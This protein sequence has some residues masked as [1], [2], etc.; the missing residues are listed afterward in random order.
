MMRKDRKLNVKALILFGAC[1]SSVIFSF[2]FVIPPKVSAASAGTTAAQFLKIALN[3]K[4]EG[5]GGAGAA[6]Y[7]D[8]IFYNPASVSKM[9]EIS[10]RAGY[11]SWFENISKSNAFCVVPLGAN[12]WK[13]AGNISYFTVGGLKEYSAEAASPSDSSVSFDRNSYSVSAALAK[14]FGKLSLGA[15]LKGV[16]EIY[17]SENGNAVAADAGF[18]FDISR[19]LSVA[20]VFQ[21]FGTKLGIAGVERKL[22]ENKK[23]SFGFHPTERFKMGFDVD[24]PSDASSRQHFGLET[25]FAKNYFLRVGW[26][27]FGE[28]SGFTFGLGM[29]FPTSGFANRPELAQSLS[30]PVI[31]VDYSYQSNSEFD[32][33]HRFSVGVR[34]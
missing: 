32:N 2:L 30:Q 4:I 27:H 24:V 23:F 26:Q 29:D 34:F 18:I 7:T 10:V 33:I 8:D 13:F 9:D 14:V 22:P 19:K 20:A 3:P 1:L 31:T 28:V 11:V 6:F 15:T 16:Y 5:M 12:N 17:G 21:N 25:E